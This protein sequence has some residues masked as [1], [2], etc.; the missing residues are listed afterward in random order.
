MQISRKKAL[1]VSSAAVMVVL[2]VWLW[3]QK[4]KP[5]E[6][7]PRTAEDILN[8]RTRLAGELILESPLAK[9]LLSKNW[10]A[11]RKDFLPARDGR[12]LAD[13]IR[14]FHIQSKSALFDANEK[15]ELLKC[16]ILAADTKEPKASQDPLVLAQIERLPEAKTNGDA[17][18]LLLKWL[19]RTGTGSELKWLAIKKLAAQRLQPKKDAIEALRSG[20]YRA[21]R[22]DSEKAWSTL[23]QMRS[24][25]VRQRLMGEAMSQFSKV[26]EH[27]QGRALGIL[28][29]GL[30]AQSPLTPKVKTITT[31]FL[32][33]AQ[34]DKIEGALLAIGWLFHSGALTPAEQGEIVRNLT[35]IPEAS[36]TPFIQA[37]SEEIIRIFQP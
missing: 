3:S 23:E 1:L 29:S 24:V 7:K 17:E 33:S 16:L 11:F 22:M 28:S 4:N 35:A 18:K 36:R 6:P 10:E 25:V 19:Q 37:K 26:P 27:Q 14:A 8:E 21:D 34:T 15:E 2:T 5:I 32:K 30:P 20:L 31:R 12:K 13:V 9:S